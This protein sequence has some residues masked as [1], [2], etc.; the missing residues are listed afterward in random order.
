MSGPF[1]GIGVRVGNSVLEDGGAAYLLDTYTAAAAY[2]LR[3]L[4][5]DQTL[6]VRIRRSSDNT[7]Q[8]IGLNGDDF[9]S[10]G[11]TT[12]TG[13]NDGFVVTWYDIVGSVD[14]TQSSTNNQPQI[15]SSGLVLTDNGRACLSFSETLPN[16]DYL[17]SVQSFS[18]NGDLSMFIVANPTDTTGHGFYGNAG[19]STPLV[20]WI[21]T[22]SNYKFRLYDGANSDLTSA[23]VTATQQLLSYFGIS[24]TNQSMYRNGVLLDDDNTFASMSA[25]TSE[26]MY[27]GAYGT[28][29]GNTSLNGNMQEL[30]LFKTNQ[31]PNRTSIE[32]DINTYYS[33]YA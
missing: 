9:D 21:D 13:A 19:I 11:A 4:K 27:V 20:V 31:T 1:V 26:T 28:G 25:I 15:I 24:N 30:I 12:F 2:S 6:T 16:Q 23:S 33:I 5:S 10:S 22:S 32:T 7:E 17:E 18:A 29:G 3:K 14:N 8:D